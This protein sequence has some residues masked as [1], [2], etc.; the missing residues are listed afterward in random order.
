VGAVTGWLLGMLPSLFSAAATRR[1]NPWTIAPARAG[2]GARLVAGPILAAFQ[3]PELRRHVRGARW[4]LAANAAAWAVGMPVLFVA[5]GSSPDPARRRRVHRRG[6]GHRRGDPW[7]RPAGS[8]PGHDA[9]RAR[10]GGGRRNSCGRRMTARHDAIVI[11]TGVGGCVTA[12]LLAS[13]GRRSSCS[14]RTRPPAASSRRCASAGS[15]WTS[16]AISSRAARVG[17]LGQV[18]RR[19]GLDRPRFLTHPVPVRSRGIFEITAPKG[20]AGLPRV[21]LE[22][23][24]RLRLP[25]AE[26][27]RVARMFFHVFTLTEP[28]LRVWDRRTLDAFVRRYTE[29][30]GAYFLVSF[31]ASIFFRAAAVAGLG[32]RI[33]PLLALGAARLPALVPRGR[34]GQ[35]R[36]GAAGCGQPRRG[37]VRGRGAGDERSAVARRARGRPRR[38]PRLS[39]AGGGRD[40]APA[41]LSRAGGGRGRCR[42]VPSARARFA[43]RATP[44]QIKL[45]LRRPLVRGGL[46]HRRPSR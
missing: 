15:R 36:A 12:A 2:G 29:H 46:P 19:L 45:A 35:L 21:A 40:L 32:R 25:P 5:A 3:V 27:L 28:E 7:S 33:D 23:A 42:L 30:P 13:A 22:A 41:D 10:G 8:R 16:A 1:L 39:R 34:H 11:G 38:R 31:L 9:D 44:H 37:E 43:R 18:L 17:P 24:R 26:A 14:R 6:G 20:R 4:W